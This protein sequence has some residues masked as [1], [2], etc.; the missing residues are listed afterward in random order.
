MLAIEL[1]EKI[2]SSQDRKID[3]TEKIILNLINR[4]IKIDD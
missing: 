1:C 3:I 2:D 4:N